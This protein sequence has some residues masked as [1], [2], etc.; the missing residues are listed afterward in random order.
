MKARTKHSEYVRPEVRCVHTGCLFSV[1]EASLHHPQCANLFSA[2]NIVTLFQPTE[3]RHSRDDMERNK[4][5][6]NMVSCVRCHAQCI[7]WT[8]E[9]NAKH[10]H[11]N[12]THP[13]DTNQIGQAY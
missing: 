1:K 6:I 11:T 4:Y 12:L 10:G 9:L 8:D 5:E 13:A 3:W 7:Q 2:R